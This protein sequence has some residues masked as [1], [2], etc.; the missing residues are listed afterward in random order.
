MK[1]KEKSKNAGLILNIQITK[2]MTS[3]PTASWQMDGETME[4][5]TV[6]IFWGFKITADA[7]H[8][9]EIKRHFLL[10]RRAMTNLDSILKNRDITSPTKVHLVKALVFPAVMYGF[11]SWTMKKS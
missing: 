6:F 3:G 8:S 2:I 4:T 7:D 9:H 1:V 10:R 5:V 11:E